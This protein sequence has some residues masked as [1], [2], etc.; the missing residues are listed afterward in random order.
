M[1]IK[2][3]H[4]K[5]NAWILKNNK[6]I[7]ALFVCLLFIATVIPVASSTDKNDINQLYNEINVD[8][9]CGCN[10]YDKNDVDDEYRWDLFPK[11]PVMS[12]PPIPLDPNGASPKPAIRYTPDEFSWRDYDGQD[13]TTPAKNQGNC[14]SCWDFA[15][16]GTLESTINI[17]EGFAD[18]DMDLS[19]QYVL[20]C[21]PAAGSCEGGRSYFAFKF[22]METT[23]EG[24]YHNGAIPETC[25]PYQANDEI[26]C[27]NKCDEWED[28]LV[29]ILD[30]GYWYADGTPADIEAIKTQ[31][32][33]NG[34]VVVSM[35]VTDDF[36]EWGLTHHNP[37]DYYHYPGPTEGSNHAI[38]TVGWKD[39]PSIGNGGYWIV[40]NSWGPH[41]GYDGFFNIEYGSLGIDNCGIKW[42][43]YDPDSFDCAPVADSGGPYYGNVGQEVAFDASGSFDPEGD[44]ISY[45]WDFGDGTNDIG[46]TTTHSY[47]QRGAYTVTLTVTDEIGKQST[48][49]T[50]A[51]IDLWMT[52]DKWTFTIDEINI[53]LSQNG[54]S[55]ALQASIE[56][57]VFTVAD[58]S[59][60]YFRLNFRGKIAGTF[61][62]QII[63][64]GSPITISG[65]ILR[66]TTIYGTILFGKA[67]LGIKEID[68]DIIGMLLIDNHPLPISI[69]LPAPGRIALK[70]DFDSPYTFL[71]F[72]FYVGKTSDFPSA[73]VS[74][75]ASIKSIYLFIL[76]LIDSSIP[77]S[78][79]FEDTVAFPA[80]PFVCVDEREITVEAGTYTAYEIS[81]GDF[82]KYYYAPAVGNIIKFSAQLEDFFEIR[83]ELKSTNYNR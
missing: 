82:L 33:E 59:G 21:L 41:F 35:L 8:E 69:P 50:V 54:Q 17:R 72:P 66:F 16:I 80:L 15:A 73:S 3:I 79:S 20:S 9:G 78:I 55:F 22:M 23:P 38:V 62:A 58:D 49:E 60:D 74:F 6:K 14:G 63:S 81:S 61:D 53:N 76:H 24:N 25:F 57:L 13:W 40:K 34:P 12:N 30:C 43:D 44:I 7:I 5:K 51:L 39:N 42:V 70:I 1:Q 71:D 37:E 52:N 77:Q 67:D 75:E 32:M 46:V 56:N 2:R 64:D 36:R 47:S 83:G 4:M 65:R 18:L 45:Y 29:P 31:V 10:R 68:A 26:P 48:S 27:S 19:E 28:L 11:C